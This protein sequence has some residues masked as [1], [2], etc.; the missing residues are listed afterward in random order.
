CSLGA[1]S[2]R[3][4]TYRNGDAQPPSSRRAG[5]NSRRRQQHGQDQPR[6]LSQPLG[7]RDGLRRPSMRTRASRGAA[8]RARGFGAGS[9]DVADRLEPLE[10]PA[11]LATP[12]P[13]PHRP[14]RADLHVVR[15]L[16]TGSYPEMQMHFTVGATVPDVLD[17]LR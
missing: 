12:Q 16:D 9:A 13:D 3:A 2:R 6:T 1:R 11:R 15:E 8:Y 14:E 7:Y 10:Q 5:D 17:Q 4:S